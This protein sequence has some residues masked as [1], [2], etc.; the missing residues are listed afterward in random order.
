MHNIEIRRPRLE[1]QNEL[2][3][4]FRT[5]VTDTFAKEGLSELIQDIES[6]IENKKQYLQSDLN[7][8]G[9]GRYFL[10]ASDK[11]GNQ[12]IGTIEFGPAS[13]LIRH[14]DRVLQEQ[15]EVGTVFVHPDVQNRGVGTLL[16]NAMLLTLLSRGIEEFCLDSGYQSAQKIWK[17]KFGEPDYLLKDYWGKGADHMIW[18]ICTDDVPIQFCR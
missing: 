14:T 3:Q 16:L 11:N 18:R 17:K 2:N 5:V 15:Y 12:V 13:E 7:T 4:F 6:E 1:D 10:I 9:E 8:S